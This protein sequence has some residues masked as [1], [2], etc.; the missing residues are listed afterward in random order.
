MPIVE[1]KIDIRPST[2]VDFFA[3]P[4]ENGLPVG[5][6]H[7]GQALLRSMREAGQYTQSITLSSDELTQTIVTTIPDL[8]TWSTYDTAL[9]IEL[10]SAYNDYLTANNFTVLT[11]STTP[12]AYNC[13][14][15]DSEFIQ[16]VVSNCH[17]I[18]HTALNGYWC[19]PER[20]IVYA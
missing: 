13:T 12:K 5:P 2:S 9:G 1:T 11:Q 10:D 18:Y 4:D 17:K 3:M 20:F 8:A 6:S 15:V 16:T 14:G 19:I 7:S